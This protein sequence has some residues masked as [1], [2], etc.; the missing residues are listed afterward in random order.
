MW[1]NLNCLNATSA[2]WLISVQVFLVAVEIREWLHE[3]TMAFA[4][5]TSLCDLWL[6]K[7]YWRVYTAQK[8]TDIHL[9]L[10]DLED[11]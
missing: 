8:P 6:F 4:S 1:Q 3:H 7:P 2:H 5:L 9:S 10:E 11:L